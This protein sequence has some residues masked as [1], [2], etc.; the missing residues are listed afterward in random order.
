MP[1][2]DIV[3]RLQ[4]AVRADTQSRLLDR[5]IDSRRQ[6]LS[7]DCIRHLSGSGLVQLVVDKTL[8]FD[9]VT[10]PR[11]S[12][13]SFSSLPFL[14]PVVGRLLLLQQY[15]G[16]YNALDNVVQVSRTISESTRT[17]RSRFMGL[18][19]SHG[20]S[21]VQLHGSGVALCPEDQIRGRGRSNQN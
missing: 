10:D 18:S 16:H 4:T 17:G 12:R 11:V 14:K 20:P 7:S 9:N 1:F 15:Q 3:D 13:C 6:L 21:L 2:K 19:P 8:S 5:F